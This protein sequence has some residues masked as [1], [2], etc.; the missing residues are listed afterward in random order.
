MTNIAWDGVYARYQAAVHAAT[1]SLGAQVADVDQAVVLDVRRAA[2]FE[3]ADQ[4]PR[5]LLQRD[6][7]V[8]QL[9]V[10]EGIAAGA[11]H[12]FQAR[13]QHRV[14]GRREG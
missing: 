8:R 2:V 13:F 3:A 9:L 1:S 5:S 12:R 4:P 14:V 10:V 6:H 7:R 11:A